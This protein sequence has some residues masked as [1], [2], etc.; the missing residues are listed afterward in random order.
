MIKRAWL[1]T[2]LA[3]FLVI[4]NHS[5]GFGITALFWWTD[6]Y[7]SVRSIPNYDQIGSFSYFLILM[8]MVLGEVAVPIFLFSSGLFFNYS[9]RGVST[10]SGKTFWLRIQSLLL[11]Y[12]AWSLVILLLDGAETI[13]KGETNLGFFDFIVRILTFNTSGHYWFVGVIIQLNIAAYFTYS[14]IKSRWK[15]CL[16]IFSVFSILN[17]CINGSILNLGTPTILSF[18]LPRLFPTSA[19]YFILG[20]VIGNHLGTATAMLSKRKK[21]LVGIGLASFLVLLVESY[22]TYPVY[23]LVGMDP[24]SRMLFIFCSLLGLLAIDDKWLPFKKYFSLL[25]KQS[26]GI[27]LVHGIVIKYGA[28]LVYHLAPQLLGYT[29]VFILMLLIVGIGIPIILM[30]LVKRVQVRFAYQWLFG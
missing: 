22:T 7:R 19:V 27:Y 28:R 29:P 2:G 20:I 3:M 25:G 23:H 13:L 12:I 10:H 24:I 6:Q 18:L 5:A 14:I 9:M 16:I 1:L 21:V 11:P 4:L 8:S 17:Y 15:L 26:Y 30:E